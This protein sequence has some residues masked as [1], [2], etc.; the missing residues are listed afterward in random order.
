MTPAQHCRGL[1]QGIGHRPVPQLYP[2]INRS[3]YDAGDQMPV[4]RVGG[5]MFGIM[6][7]NDSNYPD[8]ARV[9]DR[10]RRS[11]WECA[12]VCAATDGGAHRCGS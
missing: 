11:A 3:I 1:S 4:F 6:I 2:A 7:C 9:M 8:P 12:A 10:N 5:L